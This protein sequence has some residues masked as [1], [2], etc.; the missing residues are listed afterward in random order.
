MGAVRT[1]A[2]STVRRGREHRR[3]PWAGAPAAAPGGGLGSAPGAGPSAPGDTLPDPATQPRGAW[4]CGRLHAARPDLVAVS[5]NSVQGWT[6]LLPAAG[7]GGRTAHS[8][9]HRLRV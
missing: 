4:D 6:A 5:R 1:R 9:G 7:R 3:T 2:G 8:R